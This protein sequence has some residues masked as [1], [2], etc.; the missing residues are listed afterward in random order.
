MSA[1]PE[2]PDAGEVLRAWIGSL[3]NVTSIVA[4]RIGLSLTG[5]QP[6]IRYALV[7]GGNLRGGAAWAR[8]QVECWGPGAGA[9]DDGTSGQLARRIMSAA[10]TLVGTI[11]GATVS[12]A[13][14][15][16]PYSRDDE[17]TGRPRTIVEVTFTVAPAA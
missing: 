11:G 2:T 10:P 12:G 7:A 13:S 9:V 4:D 1:D 15:D 8:Y 17:T 6:G 14:A 3:A 5:A 16:Y